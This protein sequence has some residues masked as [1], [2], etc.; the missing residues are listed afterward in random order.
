MN[1]YWPSQTLFIAKRNQ[2][3]KSCQSTM[4][5]NTNKL[6]CFN[7]RLIRLVILTNLLHN[8]NY[9][10]IYYLYFFIVLSF[11]VSSICIIYQLH[12]PND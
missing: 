6:Q 2:K 1:P 3:Q 4:T 11:V 5:T 10:Y 7:M 9:C 8:Q 12:S